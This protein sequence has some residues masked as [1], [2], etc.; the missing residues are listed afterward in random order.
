M[1]LKFLGSI[2]PYL[3]SLFEAQAAAVSVFRLID[4]VIR[5][6]RCFIKIPLFLDYRMKI[7][8]SMNPIYGQMIVISNSNQIL[9]VILNLI[10]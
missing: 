7:R 6:I 10:V 5:F 8:A 3:E 1:C 4:E 9:M 2:G